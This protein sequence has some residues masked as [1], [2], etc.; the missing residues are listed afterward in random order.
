MHSSDLEAGQV[1]IYTDGACSGNPGP[2]GY[3]SVMLFKQGETI[4]RKE[5]SQGYGLTTNNR[6]EMLGVIRALQALKRASKVSIFSDSKYIIDA[7]EKKW[8]VGWKKKNWINSQKKPVKNRDL[9][10]ELDTLLYFH[11]ISWNWVKGHAGI[12]ENERCDELAVEASKSSE[13]L[14]DEGYDGSNS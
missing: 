1:V 11:D 7:I 9:W 4:H 12:E 8:L 10:E 5:L 13:L 14:E 2:G 3:G 6:M